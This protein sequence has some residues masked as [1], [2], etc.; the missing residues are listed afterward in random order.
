MNPG[1]RD[2][3]ARGLS[4]DHTEVRGL[5]VNRPSKPGQEPRPPRA[6][7]LN[8]HKPAWL[9]GQASL[10]VRVGGG[11]SLGPSL[12]SRGH[13][14]WNREFIT[15]FG[16]QPGL[17]ITPEGYIS[18]GKLAAAF[19]SHCRSFTLDFIF[20]RP[21]C[22]SSRFLGAL[23]GRGGHT[24]CVPREIGTFGDVRA[25]RWAKEGMGPPEKKK[26][27]SPVKLST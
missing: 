24:A 27:K 16:R 20:S 9:G 14:I 6:L 23:G 26:K 17:E 13:A 11:D 12:R 22:P 2:S 7:E 1:F 3:K 5:R 8:P 19:Q 4:P 25:P 21:P 18:I 10:G 15:A